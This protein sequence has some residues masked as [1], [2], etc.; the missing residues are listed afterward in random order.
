MN[1]K[2]NMKI[3]KIQ[4]YGLWFRFYK[5]LCNIFHSE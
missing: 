1:V 5:D 4:L 3:M 2:K